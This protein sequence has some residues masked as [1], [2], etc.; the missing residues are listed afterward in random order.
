[1]NEQLDPASMSDA[2]AIRPARFLDAASPPHILTLILATGLGSLALNLFLP[3]LPT[4]AAFYAADIATV[5]LAVSLYLAA[6]AVLQPVIGP[7]SDR[8]GRRPVLIVCVALAIV[9]TIGAIYAPTIEWFLACRIGQAVSVAGMVIGRAAIRDTVGM[10]GAASKIGYVTMAMAVAPMLGPIIGGWLDELYGWQSTFW[11]I[12]G[13]GVVALVMV[14]AD[15]GETNAH[16]GA[17][18]ASQ[19]AAY[20]E[21]MRSRRLWGYTAT[22]TFS[23]GAF[24]AFVGGGPFLANEYF[25]LRPSEFGLYFAF[26]PVGYILGNFLS[27]R[28]S[29]R[30]GVNV[31]IAIGAAAM[32]AGLAAAVALS[33]LDLRSPVAFFGFMSFVG[34]GNGIALPNSMAGIVS[35]R[36]RLSGAASGLGGFLQLGGAAAVSVVGGH[37]VGPQTG[38]TPLSIL[39][40]ACALASLVAALY[41]VRVAASLPP[42]DEA[43]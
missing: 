35:V 39:M 22:A 11:L 24:F 41:V 43:R 21:L 15:M 9:A 3:S 13:F 28:F 17:S 18:F 31:M 12:A 19:L 27:G 30:V 5:Q 2:T 16:R 10:A 6:S 33:L 36:P 34:L 42:E 38:A 40:F 32:A 29:R 4:I 14:V 8:Y 1:M 23:S 20:P 25:N 26:A 7:L 37:L